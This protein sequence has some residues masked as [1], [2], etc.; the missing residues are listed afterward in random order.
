M[1]SLLWRSQRQRIERKRVLGVAGIEVNHIIRAILRN[2]KQH[3]LGEVPVRVDK[4]NAA[5]GSKIGRNQVFQER[6]FPLVSYRY[7]IESDPCAIDLIR[8]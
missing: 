7:C 1:W 2:G 8:S 6:R 3:S 4:S 5:A